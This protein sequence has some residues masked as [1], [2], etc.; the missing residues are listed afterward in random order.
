MRKRGSERY[1]WERG[2]EEETG[3]RISYGGETGEKPRG[4]EK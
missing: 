3:E 1:G 4:T 2:E